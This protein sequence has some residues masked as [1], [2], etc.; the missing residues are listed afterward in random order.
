MLEEPQS[1]LV[2]GFTVGA[3]TVLAFSKSEVA[4]QESKHEEGPGKLDRL[5]AA[6][7]QSAGVWLDSLNSLRVDGYLDRRPSLAWL[8]PSF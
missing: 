4:E 7:R 8:G 6:T 2:Y 5:S 3:E 1:L